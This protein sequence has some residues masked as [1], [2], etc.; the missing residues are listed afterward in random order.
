MY[1][2]TRDIAAENNLE[3]KKLVL[4]YFDLVEKIKVDI[5]PFVPL[6]RNKSSVTPVKNR[7][8]VYYFGQ[9]DELKKNNFR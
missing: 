9:T 3:E 7:P 1:S 2:V 4:T 6:H 8:I 5:K